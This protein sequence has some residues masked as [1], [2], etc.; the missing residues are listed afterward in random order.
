M[1]R[2]LGRKATDRVTGFS[3]TIIGICRYIY[4]PM[5]VCIESGATMDLQG[6]CSRTSKSEWFDMARVNVGD[7]RNDL[8]SI[9]A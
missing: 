6:G 7:P 2:Y 3:G 9:D 5:R 4:G 8:P 1:E